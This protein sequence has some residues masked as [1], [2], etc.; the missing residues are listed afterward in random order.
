MDTSKIKSHGIPVFIGFIVVALVL[1]FLK[2]RFGIEIGDP[3]DTNPEPEV[4]DPA[5]EAGQED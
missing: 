5:L 4:G 1:G 3:V 2:S